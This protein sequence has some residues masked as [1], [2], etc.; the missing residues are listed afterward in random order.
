M[1]TAS[2]VDVYDLEDGEKPHLELLH[3]ISTPSIDGLSLS[4][5]SARFAPA[6][7][8][9]ASASSCP[10]IYAVLNSAAPAR[11]DRGKARKA[12]VVRFDATCEESGPSQ[13]SEDEKPAKVKGVQWAVGAKR[14]VA[15]KPV[16][17]FDISS[18]GK[19]VAFGCSDLSI[20]ML[21]ASTL[22]VS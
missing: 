4:F 5:R 9:P 3:S 15:S 14:E 18:D 12:F 19:L 22:A 17:V 11:R 13:D 6:A 21:D 8:P 2:K 1:T 16:T 20:G 7:Q 10:G